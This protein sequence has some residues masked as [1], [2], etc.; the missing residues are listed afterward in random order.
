ML[1]FEPESLSNDRNF[2]FCC[3]I[4]WSEKAFFQIEYVFARLFLKQ[5]V[6]VKISDIHNI[7]AS[8]Y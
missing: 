1:Y 3:K 5:T 8:H 6:H 7:D 4:A 2:T